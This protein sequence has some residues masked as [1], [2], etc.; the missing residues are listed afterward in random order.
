MNHYGKLTLPP[1]YSDIRKRAYKRAL[2]RA[3]TQGQTQY[4][5]RT[6][7]AA[8]LGLTTNSS[9]SLQSTHNVLSQDRIRYQFW[10]CGG[11]TASRF[12]EIRHWIATHPPTILVLTETFWQ[13]NQ[14]WYEPSQRGGLSFIHTGSGKA[15][16][17]GILVIIPHVFA[18]P[19]NIKHETL[20]AG[21]LLRVRLEAE[22]PLDCLCVYGSSQE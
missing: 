21:R 3:A 1:V 6:F 17:A 9:R 20:V 5:G 4:R 15:R 8:Q 16:S 22:P 10:N 2:R 7:T 14:E 13:D 12:Q 19:R 18:A 11:L